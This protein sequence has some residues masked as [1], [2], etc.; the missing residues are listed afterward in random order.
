MVL[1]RWVA[2]LISFQAG[3]CSSRA[4]CTVSRSRSPG[5]LQRTGSDVGAGVEFVHE[6]FEHSGAQLGSAQ[7]G[8]AGPQG[9]VEAGEGVVAGGGQVGVCAGEFLGDGVGEGVPGG[10]GLVY[11]LLLADRFAQ[12]LA[13]LLAGVPGPGG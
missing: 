8:K 6:V 9:G 2:R 7:A 10:E 1:G 13:E 4:V 3:W 5:M 12:Q 11:G